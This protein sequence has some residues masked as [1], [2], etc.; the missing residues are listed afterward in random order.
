MRIMASTCRVAARIRHNLQR[1]ATLLP[2]TGLSSHCSAA[3][4]T[5]HIAP[6]DGSRMTGSLLGAHHCHR[7]LTT[8]VPA[9]P[10]L[11]TA[12][13][14]LPGFWNVLPIGL[15]TAGRLLVQLSARTSRPQRDPPCATSLGLHQQPALAVVSLGSLFFLPLRNDRLCPRLERTSGENR[16]LAC[17]VLY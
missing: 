17:L 8:T 2:V 9:L 4:R 5:F 1:A 16:V 11:R 10:H 3:R 12:A 6:P 7:F 14:A 13:L 15:D